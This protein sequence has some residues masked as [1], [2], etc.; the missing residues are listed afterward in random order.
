MPV[1]KLTRRNLSS[2]PVAD[3]PVI[4]YDEDLKGFGLRVMPSGRKTWIVEYRPNGGGRGVSKRRH[5]VA[6]YEETTPEGARKLAATMLASVRLGADPAEERAEARDALTLREVADL[7]FA[8]HVDVKRKAS[9][10]ADYRRL[11]KLHILPELG[12]KKA[13][14]VSEA[15]LARIHS[16]MRATKYRANRALAVVSSLY[17]FAE[18][19]KLVPAGTNPAAHI[20][21]YREDGRETFLSSEDLARLGEAIREAETVGIPWE[22]DPTKK[23]KHVP[24][25][26]RRTVIDPHAAGALRL[27]LLTGA[28]LREI[29]G[30]RWQWVDVERGLLLLPDSKTGKKAVVLSAPA[31]AVLS[32]LPRIG[33]YVIAGANAGTKDEKPRADLKRPWAAVSKRA[34]LEGVRLHDLRHT[35]AS[36][37]AGAGLGLP[38]IGKL[39]GHANTATTERYAHLDNDPLRK[40]ANRIGNDIAAAMGEA[41]A[42]G[43]RVIKLKA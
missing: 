40:A 41:P 25:E 13:A 24:K 36:V 27:L 29:L 33:A 14:M 28:R 23:A 42:E 32:G 1:L 4:F 12:S 30:L 8:D 38:I 26:N 35:N 16:R 7:F 31:L 43:G 22:P 17:A 11:L 5:A 2:L 15:D 34:G 21:K 18:R 6:A 20:E 37:G 3:K 39:L 9:T 19:R 10:A